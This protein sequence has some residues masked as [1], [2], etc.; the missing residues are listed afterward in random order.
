MSI[1][2]CT[3]PVYQHRRTVK[4]AAILLDDAHREKD[5]VVFRNTT[6]A[7]K[8][9]RRDCDGRFVVLCIPLTTYTRKGKKR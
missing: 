1:E 6:K 8:L 3:I 7:V 9:W 4:R 2:Q 5:I